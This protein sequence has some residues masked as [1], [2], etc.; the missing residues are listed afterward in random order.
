MILRLVGCDVKETG[1]MVAY[2]L[3]IEVGRLSNLFRVTLSE[4]AL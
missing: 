2:C 1:T 3:Y 4:D